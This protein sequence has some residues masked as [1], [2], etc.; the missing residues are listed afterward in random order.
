MAKV[1]KTKFEVEVEHSGDQKDFDKLFLRTSRRMKQYKV[2]VIETETKR[3]TKSKEVT[4]TM[5]D[6]QIV[7]KIVMKCFEAIGYNYISPNKFY[8][9]CA[10]KTYTVKANNVGYYAPGLELQVKPPH[11]SGYGKSAYIKIQNNGSVEVRRY[12]YD[13]FAT[14]VSLADPNAIKLLK[15]AIKKKLGIS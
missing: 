2:K 1:T 11:R 7:K 5:Q 9:Q 6:T 3:V 15:E 14:E 8:D 10:S 4:Q 12:S 13:Q